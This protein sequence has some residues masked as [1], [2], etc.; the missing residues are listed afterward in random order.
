MKFLRLLVL[1]SLITLGA[2][3]ARADSP[4]TSALQL[5]NT[6]LGPYKAL[7]KLSFDS[8]QKGDT[9]TAAVLARILERTWNSGTQDLAKKS[10]SRW[11]Q[12]NEALQHFVAPVM[13]TRGAD[14]AIVEVAYQ[15][16][17]EKLKQA[18]G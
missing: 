10:T 13:D 2:A 6:P 3:A 18:E 17:T 8:F 1:T 4:H 15:E 7:A 9:Q 5:L 11:R 16:F 12:A 14:A